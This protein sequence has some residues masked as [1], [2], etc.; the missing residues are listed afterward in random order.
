MQ[1]LTEIVGLARDAGRL[2]WRYLPL[3]V[4]WF[5]A[6]WI[7]QRGALQLS[8]IVG[9]RQQ[10]LALLIF[11]AGVLAGVASLV[12][13]I[14]ALEPG[15]PM[16]SRLRGGGFGLPERLRPPRSLL[17]VSPRGAT[18]A[19][20]LGPF[21][22]VYAVWGLV[23]AQ[24]RE[25]YVANQIRYGLDPDSWSVDLRRWQSYAVMAVAAWLIKQIAGVIHRRTGLTAVAVVAVVADAVFV[26][27][28]FL[29]L[30]RA[31][32]QLI[33]WV[34]T[35]RIAL[36]VID[37]W[38]SGLEALPE[39]RLPFDL[40]L[41]EAVAEA[42]DWLWGTG[43]PLAAE[44][45]LLPLM[46]LAL[47]GVV[48]GWRDVIDLD[49]RSRLGRVQQRLTSAWEPL[50]RVA[51]LATVDLREKYLPVAHGFR[52]LRAAGP[53]FIGAY[54]LVAT[55]LGW[56]QDGF[57]WLTTTLIGPVDSATVLLLDPALVLLRGVIFTTAT[58]A[59]Y[60]TA[61]DRCL[62]DAAQA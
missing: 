15:L 35:R 19:L 31:V 60:A 13:M 41:P 27:T 39:I 57:G 6:G 29:A 22:A 58:A 61:F 54:L 7:A 23:D 5:A 56:L 11:I 51:G 46:W 24:V 43:L 34:S 18:V 4:T 44:H 20:A 42:V 2:W 9:G 48:F 59:L 55:A 36:Q 21:L 49:G 28:S 62:G 33:E 53:R 45:L 52:L 38:R 14:H 32:F 30:Y 50:G 12:I 8:I 26:F 37:V 25:L 47:A 16:L 3:L 40:T 17:A 10:G 1:T